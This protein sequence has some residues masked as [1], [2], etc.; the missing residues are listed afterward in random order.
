M[1]NI[2]QKLAEMRN[3][4]N[5]VSEAV[6]ALA[7]QPAPKA[8]ILD[9]ELSGNKINGGKIT[10]FSSVGITDTATDT[11]LRVANDGVTVTVLHVNRIANPLTIQGELTVQGTISATRLNVDEISADIRNERT[12]NLEFKAENGSILNKGLVWTGE[13]NTRQLTMQG[14]PDRL[15][16]SE[17]IDIFR[18]KEYRI[19]N[20]PVL[21]SDSL[22]LGVVNSNL[23]KVGTLQSL[24]VAGNIVIDEHVYYDAD[25]M[26]LGLGTSE[27][28]GAFSIES[29][30]HQFIIDPTDDFKFKLGTWTTSGIDIVTD[31]T[32]RLSIDATGTINVMSKTIFN[33]K[34]GIGV[35]NFSNDVDITTAGPVRFQNKKQEVGSS[36][37]S[38]GAYAKGDLVWND[39]PRPTGY[40]GWICVREGTPGE[41]KPFGQI[42]A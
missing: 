14:G 27:P 33:N 35:K 38:Q 13:R 19:N 24:S 17:T 37:P 28:N 32:K 39:N 36:A 15:F 9:R 4:F 18:D 3:G 7:N 31:D 11:Q 1:S 41:W 42:S 34:V 29:L 2:E 16:S 21:S 26:R 20:V 22:G 8:T 40:V 10:N 6:E 23:Q 25:T 30:D 5:A 12:S